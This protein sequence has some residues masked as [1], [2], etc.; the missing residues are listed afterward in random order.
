MTSGYLKSSLVYCS[1]MRK[2]QLP[3]LAAVRAQ[4]PMSSKGS[5]SS[6]VSSFQ[7]MKGVFLTAAGVGNSQKCESTDVFAVPH[8]QRG[9]TTCKNWRDTT[10]YS[11]LHF[12]EFFPHLFT[13]SI[14]VPRKVR[15]M[16]LNNIPTITAPYERASISKHQTR[17]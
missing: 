13:L 8:P 16:Y 12:K 10:N 11:T 15:E 17:C 6:L 14:I 5:A 4:K 7:N 1:W 9:R 2:L 3:H